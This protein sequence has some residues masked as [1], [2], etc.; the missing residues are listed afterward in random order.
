M[1]K[2]E[3]FF[4]IFCRIGIHDYKINE[5]NQERCTFC[6]KEKDYDNVGGLFPG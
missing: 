2:L 1:S 3:S 4:G 5:R 6:N